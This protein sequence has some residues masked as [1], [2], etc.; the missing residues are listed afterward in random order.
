MDLL[1]RAGL[2]FERHRKHGMSTLRFGELLVSSGL[3]LSDRVKW[4]TFHSGYDFGY[5]LKILTGAPMPATQDG[6]FEL[7]HLFF[8]VVYD[9]KHLISSVGS[10][11]GG[12]NRIAS[13]LGVD[14]VGPVHQAGSDSLVTALVFFQLRE[15]LLADTLRDAR[16]IGRLFGLS[17]VA[18]GRACDRVQARK[19]A[20]HEGGRWAA[21]AGKTGS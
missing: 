7:L 14:R 13:E 11:H 2:Q 21:R 20:L 1:R 16:A 18:S 12:L 3:V 10:L 17:D 15:R 4:I 6:F 5:L 8:P 19:S 9:V